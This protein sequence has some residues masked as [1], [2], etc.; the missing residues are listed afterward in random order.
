MLI[1]QVIIS[2]FKSY[3]DQTAVEPFSAGHNV[4]GMSNTANNKLGFW[5]IIS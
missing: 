3:R 1:K 4:V 2:G 5:E